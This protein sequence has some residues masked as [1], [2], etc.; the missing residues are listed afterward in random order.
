VAVVTGAGIPASLIARAI[1]G[2]I[3]RRGVPGYQTIA[4]PRI[5]GLTRLGA[6]PVVGR[7]VDLSA[8]AGRETGQKIT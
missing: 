7:L 8:F 2:S 5:A 4:V 6:L 1:I 3:R